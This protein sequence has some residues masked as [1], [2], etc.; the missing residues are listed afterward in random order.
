M[1]KGGWPAWKHL[2][3]TAAKILGGKRVQRKAYHEKKS[4]II[5]KDF[6]SFKLDTKRYKLFRAFSLYEQVRERY[7]KKSSDS[8]ILILR[9]HNKVTKLAVIDIKLLAKFMDFVREKGGQ[10]EFN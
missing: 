4:D 1:S 10:G 9:Q 8:A 6:P 7:C 5:I 3:D 2:E